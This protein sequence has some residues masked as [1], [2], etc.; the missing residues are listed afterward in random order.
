MRDVWGDP[1][2]T[3]DLFPDGLVP[4]ILRLIV[5]AWEAFRKPNDS[6]LEP[7]ITR[8]F[9]VELESLKRRE[10]RLPKVLIDCEVDA[11]GNVAGQIDVRMIRGKRREVYFGI[12]AKKLN[13]P[14]KSNAGEYVGPEGMGRFLSGKYAPGQEH[15]G[16][17]GYVMDGNCHEAARRIR[18]RMESARDA[19]KIAD[20]GDVLRDSNMLPDQTDIYESKHNLP[21]R[22]LTLHHLM[23]AA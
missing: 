15:S 19:L 18:A 5:D 11:A 4:D 20:D 7:A 3:A 12:E 22:L 23:L 2:D 13:R 21:D 9:A 17:I 1:W 16:M 14:E 6:E 10:E 8:R